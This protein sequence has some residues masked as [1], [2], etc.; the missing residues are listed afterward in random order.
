MTVM[1]EVRSVDSNPRW[2]NLVSLNAS[3]PFSDWFCPWYCCPLGSFP[4]SLKAKDSILNTILSSFCFLCLTF[5]CR[6]NC[7]L[8]LEIAL[9]PDP[10]A[11]L[12]LTF[13]TNF[14]CFPLQS[15]Y[16]FSYY[17]LYTSTHQ[18]LFTIICS[19]LP[20]ILLWA[21]WG[22]VNTF[23]SAFFF[24]LDIKHRAWHMVYIS[25]YWLLTQWK[26]TACFSNEG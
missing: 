12:L 7:L 4:S 19:H 25:K 10:S 13:K 3:L 2:K 24:L 21:L 23:Y 18:I 6:L 26:S 20:L 17:L 15:L 14:S 9:V 1:K 11:K 5:L 22:R 16:V 8:S